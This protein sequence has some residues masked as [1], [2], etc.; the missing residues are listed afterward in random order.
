MLRLALESLPLRNGT[1][2]AEE[3]ELNRL[4]Q[5]HFTVYNFKTF[6]LVLI[7]ELTVIAKGK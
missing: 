3:W 1:V 5:Q 7:A 4:A 2:E 6:L